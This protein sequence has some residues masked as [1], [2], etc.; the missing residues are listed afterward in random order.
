MMASGPRMPKYLPWNDTACR[1]AGPRP[2]AIPGLTERSQRA[3]ATR[4]RPPSTGNTMPVT[5]RDSSLAR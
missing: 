4:L 3:G 5:Q 2:G 1:P